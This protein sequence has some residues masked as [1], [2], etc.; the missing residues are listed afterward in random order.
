MSRTVHVDPLLARREAALRFLVQRIDY[1]R[2]ISLPYHT[3]QIKLSRMRELLQRLGN[4]QN[5]LRIVHVAGT[6]GKG[7]TTAMVAAALCAAGYRVGAFTSPHLDRVEE[8]LAI[9]GRPCSA[10]EFV[11]LVDRVTPAVLAMDRQAACL[12]GEIGP[13]YFEITTAMAL[14]HFC[15]KKVDT[16]VLEVGMGGRLDSTNVCQPAVAVITS[17]SFDHTKQLG[18]TLEAIAREKA[19]IIKPGVPVVSGVT[20]PGPQCVIR[21]VC[22]QRGCPLVELG[23]DFSFDYTPPRALEQAPAWGRLDFHYPALNG[24]AKLPGL[25]LGLVGRHQ[26]ANAAIALATLAHLNRMGWTIPEQ[27]MREGL[28]GVVWPA[29]AEVI[30][31]RPVILI[32]A[33]H[34]L[35]SVEA[36]VEVLEE[37]FSPARR[38]LIFATTQEKDVRGMLGRLLGRFDRIVFT[39]YLNNPRGVPPEELA[40]VA[41]ELS[42]RDYPICARP[43]EAWDLVRSWAAADDILCVTGSFFIAAEMRLQIQ[44]R[45]LTIEATAPPATLA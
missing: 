10:E 18:N 24:Q 27:A 39:R 28:A 4:P 26:A 25:A 43:A 33:A 5:H 14:L 19:G 8:R 12:P 2:T 22:Q 41:K 37:S 21:E 13:T 7:S 44:N 40:A 16:A 1:E 9:D 6:K 15:R 11:D 35:A 45:P 30:A 32:D 42:G 17:I 34:N 29:R 20:T 3:E 31:R 23:T 36:L 38:L